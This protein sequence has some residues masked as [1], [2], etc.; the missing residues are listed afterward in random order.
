MKIELVVFDMAGAP[1][2]DE[3]SV[4]RCLREALEGAGLT[5]SAAA[6]NEVMGLPKPEALRALIQRSA[7]RERFEGRVA[8]IHADFVRRM[9]RFYQSDPSVRE[10]SGTSETFRRLRQAGIKV[11]LNT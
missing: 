10:I 11:A 5:V 8:E 4:N 6:V 1:V 7:L 3:D 2:Q 9:F